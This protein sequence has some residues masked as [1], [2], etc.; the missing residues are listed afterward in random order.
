MKVSIS[1]QNGILTLPT[2]FASFLGVTRSGQ[3]HYRVKYKV[4]AV[5]AIKRRAY[6]VKISVSTVSPTSK[7]VPSLQGTTGQELVQGLL[8]QTPNKI[9]A[10]RAFTKGLVLS[11]TSDLT[12]KFPNDKTRELLNLGQGTT[13][14]QKK[15]TKLVKASELTRENVSQ[16]IHQIPLYQPPANQ[17]SQ[18]ISPSENAHRLL[19]QFQIDPAV[20]GEKTHLFAD[21]RKALDG[22]HQG[23]GGIAQQASK[24][25]PVGST[26]AAFGILGAI[27]KPNARPS[28]QL[29]LANDDFVLVPTTE[30]TNELTVEEDLFIDAS[31]VGDQFYLLF[32]LHDI[33]GLELASTSMLV[34]HS[35]NVAL[36]S[37]PVTA[38][39]LSVKPCSGYNKL[40]LK[41]LDENGVGVIIFRKT[42]EL[43]TTILD[44]GFV[45]VAKFPIRKQDGTKWYE[46]RFPSMK[47]VV[48]RA[49][50]YNQQEY[51]S[52]EFSSAMCSPVNKALSIRSSAAKRRSYLSLH[53]KV[54]DRSVQ[55]ELN[56][57]PAN[58]LA[59]KVFRRDLSLFQTIDAA[60][61]IG[62]QILMSEL[63]TTDMRF[64]FTDQNP[65]DKRDYEYLVR[66]TY[67]DGAELWANPPV[68]IRYSP[69]TNGI[70]TTVASP[71]KAVSV[72]L[73]QD[74]RFTLTT[75]ISEGKIDQVK[76]AMGQQGILGFFQDDLV[77]NREYLQS[78]VAYHIK[79]SNLT[80]GE[81]ED[82]G[83]TM[84]SNF[85]DKV[86]GAGKGVQPTRVGCE[87]EYA[88]TTYFRNATTLLS[89]F[90]LTVT[91]ATNSARSYTY[92]PAKWQNPITLGDGSLV[93]DASLRRNHA[94][95]EF[96]AA[97]VGSVI[98]LRLS[99]AESTPLAQNATATP[100]GKGRVLVQWEL[101]G[102]TKEIDHFLITREEL[103]M[104]TV[105][106]KAHA[107]TDSRSIQFIDDLNEKNV[108]K[109]RYDEGALSYLITPILY[110]YTV[111]QATKTPQV[112]AKKPR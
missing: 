68:Q 72:G 66:L 21:T 35:R 51:K 1:R 61:Q 93:T 64:Y 86:Q 38:P 109:N 15:S 33:S 24:G 81:V 32:Q 105:V 97:T 96:T 63:P 14:F 95:N 11:L 10:S 77:N 12:S 83:V 30:E 25:A 46:D 47:P 80:T 56:D 37:L 9:E 74:I 90:E 65:I 76:R 53:A 98:H 44:N 26:R 31:A 110:D 42:V 79:R 8:R 99:L 17:V 29:G 39:F 87:Y 4:D 34:Q 60:E 45:Q 73:E 82:M 49:V 50:A 40:E 92:S 70:L 3:F 84:D 102:N 69:V 100:I 23:L 106:G 5:R 94:T 59:M 67:R 19:L 2:D 13:L 88:I 22:V 78:L 57:I 7:S 85:S 107:M 43:Q 108:D 28:D 71:M 20:V 36:F 6:F 104:V 16:P 91:D 75:S 111:G 27:S 58:V 62:D 18:G 54:L 112:I 52:S 55:L 101:K 103:G 48:Y 89:T 41:Q